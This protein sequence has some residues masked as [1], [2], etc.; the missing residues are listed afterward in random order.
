[1]QACNNSAEKY[2]HVKNFCCELVV[3]RKIAFTCLATCSD[4]SASLSVALCLSYLFFPIHWSQMQACNKQ[5]GR[6][7]RVE[8]NFCA[9]FN[10]TE[11]RFHVSSYLNWRFFESFGFFLRLSTLFP[12]QLE[13]NEGLQHPS[14]KYWHVENFFRE[15]VVQ[16]KSAFTCLAT[17]TDVFS[18]VLVHSRDFSLSFL[19]N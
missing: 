18:S 6:Y 11:N 3:K 1:M 17:Y 16:R 14:E 13:P 10:R 12:L 9:T 19:Y 4:V 8:E 5:V 15:L 2:W 7:W